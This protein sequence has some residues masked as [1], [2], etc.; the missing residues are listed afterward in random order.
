LAI[1]ADKFVDGDIIIDLVEVNRYPI[2]NNLLGLCTAISYID[3][4]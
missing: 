2:T 1:I 4:L 3:R